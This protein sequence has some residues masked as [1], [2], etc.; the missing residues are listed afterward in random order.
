MQMIRFNYNSPLKQ[1]RITFHQTPYRVK[2]NVKFA[3]SKSFKI[4]TQEINDSEFVRKHP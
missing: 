1:N 4:Q 3:I 2:M